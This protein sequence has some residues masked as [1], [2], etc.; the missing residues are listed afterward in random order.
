MQVTDVLGGSRLLIQI[1]VQ[2]SP[3]LSMCV[4]VSPPRPLTMD[5]YAKAAADGAKQAADYVAESVRGTLGALM[6][7]PRAGLS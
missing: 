6:P 2:L 4:C 7:S 5:G 1:S 3:Q